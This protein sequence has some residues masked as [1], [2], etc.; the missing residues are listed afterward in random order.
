[1]ATISN[2]LESIHQITPGER[3]HLLGA[4]AKAVARDLPDRRPGML[5]DEMGKPIGLFLPIVEKQPTP[6]EMTPADRAEL[7]RRLDTID[8]SITTEELKARIA[9]G[10]VAESAKP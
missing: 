8:Q 7:Q 3:A 10:D 4:L 6:P 1:M 5:T 2:L 9:R